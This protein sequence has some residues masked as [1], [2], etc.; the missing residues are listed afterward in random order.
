MAA[1]YVSLVAVRRG[2]QT[3]GRRNAEAA[4]L[5]TL[6]G[7]TIAT[8]AG[9]ALDNLLMLVVLRLAGVAR[10]T[11][12]A[13]FLL[14][15]AVTLAL[16][17]AGTGL[18]SVLPMHRI[19]LLGLVPLALGAVGL[20]AA[21]RH[22][23]TAAQ[24]SAAVG[25]GGVAGIAS[26]QVASS[27]DTLAAFLPLFA[28]TIRPQGLVIALGFAVMTLAW[29]VISGWLA[30]SRRATALIRPFERFVRPAVLMLVGLYILANTSTDVEPDVAAPIE[31][32]I[33]TPAQR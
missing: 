13:G 20:V 14:G 4:E 5:L 21:V 29:L 15:S 26:T 3:A 25:S 17:A 8:F 7:V 24:A 9:T 31:A 12:A 28:D 23:G 1:S 32:A 11:V 30:A 6:F 18:A 10:P 33:T 19:G 2:A 27:V 22:S 16:C